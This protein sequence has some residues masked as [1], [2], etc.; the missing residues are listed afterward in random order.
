[1]RRIEKICICVISVLLFLVCQPIFAQV[2]LHVGEVEYLEIPDPPYDGIIE[3]SNWTTGSGVAIEDG[4]NTY[5]AIVKVTRYY[6]GSVSVSVTYTYYY[7]DSKWNKRAAQG[8]KT[9]SI[10]CIPI[11]VSMDCG[12]ELE[13]DL[14]KST[15][16]NTSF[17]SSDSG[18]MYGIEYEWEVEDPTVI[19]LTP[20]STKRIATVKGLR[21]GT[22]VITL[23]PKVGPVITCNVRVVTSEPPKEIKLSP[24]TMTLKKG[25]TGSFTCVFYPENTGAKVTWSSGDESIATVNESGKVTAME[26]GTCTI[27][28]TTDNGLTATATVNVVSAPKAISIKGPSTIPVG[29]SATLTAEIKPEGSTSELT[30]KNDNRSVLRLQPSGRIKGLAP[31][32]AT[33]TVTTENDITA[34][35]TVT[36]VP[37]DDDM[38][39]KNVIT[40][41][42]YLKEMVKRISK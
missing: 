38:N 41:V 28:A 23:D 37:V 42:K 17:P 25:Q 6:T 35:F 36:V 24:E 27:T 26:E 1:M 39:R 31:G 21:T 14:G 18:W 7:Y 15:K 10:S 11:T 5:G 3:H 34:S 2:K 4:D 16:I 30:W 9:W 40:R 13:V 8:S 32:E 29:Y 22:T 20:N 12:N 33:I 19:S